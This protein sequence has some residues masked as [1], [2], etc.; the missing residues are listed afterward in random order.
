MSSPAKTEKLK[1]DHTHA[2]AAKPTRTFDH[3][4][5]RIG[6]FCEAPATDRSGRNEF[7][8]EPIP[9]RTGFNHS[10][11]PHASRNSNNH[12]RSPVRQFFP[13]P[14]ARQKELL[15]VGRGE[16]SERRDALASISDERL[17]FAAS[18]TLGQVVVGKVAFFLFI[19]C[20]GGS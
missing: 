18:K 6:E 14:Q 9:P 5:F 13:S 1:T 8:D 2:R 19:R 16:L 20:F 3:Q 4:P 17:N 15:F 10:R 12:A 11:K 7:D